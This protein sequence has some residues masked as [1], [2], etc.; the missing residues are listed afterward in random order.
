MWI[1]A[2]RKSSTAAESM[3]S[4]CSLSTVLTVSLN[5]ES[6]Y[7]Y[8]YIVLINQSNWMADDGDIQIN[9]WMQEN[10]K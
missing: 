5:I 9:A 10:R 7:K 6:G 2:V 1:Q 8:I 4:R 3:L